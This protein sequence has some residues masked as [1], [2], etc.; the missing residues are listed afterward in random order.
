MFHFIKKKI[1][2]IKTGRRLDQEE[3]VETASPA[4][5]LE[6]QTPSSRYTSKIQHI[7]LGYQASEV[8]EAYAHVFERWLYFMYVEQEHRGAVMIHDRS[9]ECASLGPLAIRLQ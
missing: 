6:P 9:V 8:L 2:N 1:T 7:N 5:V 3:K 4:S